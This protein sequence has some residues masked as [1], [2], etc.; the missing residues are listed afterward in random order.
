MMSKSCLLTFTSTSRHVGHTCT[1]GPFRNLRRGAVW[2]VRFGN[3][4][5]S[6]PHK[7]RDIASAEHVT[8]PEVKIYFLPLNSAH[9]LRKKSKFQGR[10]DTV[11]V[12]NRSVGHTVLGRFSCNTWE[13]MCVMCDVGLQAGNQFYLFEKHV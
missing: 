1:L 5:S 7:P 4:V 10:F 11:Y 12:S 2:D 3:R 13:A 8:I 9:D 6:H